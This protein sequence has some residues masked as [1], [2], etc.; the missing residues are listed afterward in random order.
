MLV[1]SGFRTFTVTVV[2]PRPISPTQCRGRVVRRG[3]RDGFVKRR[4]R[5]VQRVRSLVQIMDNDCAGFGGHEGNL[6]Y[7]L[8]VRL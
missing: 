4:G 2:R 5:H 6:P 7:S 3:L 8:F 1:T